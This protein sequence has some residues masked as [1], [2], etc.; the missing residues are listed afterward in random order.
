M[1][2][3]WITAWI[4]SAVLSAGVWLC[5]RRSGLGRWEGLAF[6]AGFF[7]SPLF[8]A[9]GG[10]NSFIYA[11]DFAVPLALFL[12]ARRWSQVPV[13][14]RNA[15]LWFIAG[16][17]AVPLL[18]LFAMADR[19]NV[20]YSAISFYRLVGAMALMCALS[21]AAAGLAERRSWMLAAFSWMNL[22][23]L[24]ATALQS[25][26]WINS[27]V[28]YNVDDS[29]VWEDR[30]SMRFI[31]AGLFRGS[32]GIIGTLGWVAFLAQYDVRGFRAVLALAGGVAG[33]M[34]I[35]L[36]GSKTSLLAVLLITIIGC[37][38]FPQILRHL[39]GRLTAMTVALAFIATAFLLRMDSDYFAYT[40][41]VLGMADD[42]FGTLSYRQERWGEA[43]DFITRAP[44]VLM[45]VATPFGSDE[46][47]LSYFHNEYIT[48]L[49]SGGIWSAGAYLAGLFIVARGA[50]RKRGDAGNSQIFAA[51]TLLCGL[52]QAMT[53]NHLLPGIFF[54]CSTTIIACG[55][56]LGFA[57]VSSCVTSDSEA[58]REELEPDYVEIPLEAPRY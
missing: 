34:V 56:G 49:M 54:L 5:A 47:G 20:M 6:A 50:F 55:Y 12:A 19:L 42:S 26:G 46:R 22:V 43:M 31:T 38:V 52:T 4:I 48:M 36:C 32:L 14:A 29:S 17:G 30:E 39:W 37:A 41:G 11:F 15:A 16:V 53:V 25:Q 58:E 2:S 1:N 27:N 40:L 23:L 18:V 3:V 24:V 28:F 10:S 7:P 51:L 45:G 44:G 9:M 33:A 8:V 21:A 35:I 13:A 57:E